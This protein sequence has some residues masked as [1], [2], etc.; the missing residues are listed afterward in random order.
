MCEVCDESFLGCQDQ[1]FGGNGSIEWVTSR[2]QFS[3]IV[4]KPRLTDWLTLLLIPD[5]THTQD[6]LIRCLKTHSCPPI[7]TWMS[8]TLMKVTHKH[9]PTPLY[10][11]HKI[12]DLWSFFLLTCLHPLLS[13]HLVIYH[14]LQSFLSF[15]S[16]SQELY[17]TYPYSDCTLTC[18]QKNVIS[19][20]QWLP[21]SFSTFFIGWHHR[22]CIS[23]IW[24]FGNWFHASWNPKY[25]QYMIDDNLSTETVLKCKQE[26]YTYFNFVV[27]YFRKTKPIICLLHTNC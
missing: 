7:D 2:A 8:P 20:E 15:L 21:I 5:W 3:T 23:L 18:I 24:C 27:S 1:C 13:S 9:G 16:K 4:E 14:K 11:N 25:D 12:K 6:C 22:G 10:S 26:Q 17:A 19:C